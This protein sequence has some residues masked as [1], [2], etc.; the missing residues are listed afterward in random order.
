MVG[1]VLST[2]FTTCVAVAVCPEASV[3]VHITF[4]VPKENTLGALFV[5]L[6]TAQLSAATGVPNTTLNAAHALFA[7]TVTFAGA[8]IV[9]FVLSTTVTTCV[10]VAVKPDA[11]VTVQVTVVFPSGKATGALFVTLAT[12]QL[13]AVT[14]VPK[15]TPVAVQAVFVF[16]VIAAGA[17]IVG[18]TLSV[19]VIT[20]VAVAEFPAASVTVQV[21]VVLPIGKE[22][23][24]LFVTLATV[25]LSAVTGVPNETPV[26]V[27]P[28]FVL[29]ESAAGAVMVGST[30]SITVIV[31]VHCAVTFCASVIV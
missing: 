11:S 19:T 26:A 15:V 7:F 1:F 20:C 13:S 31:D 29:T 28:V 17:T 2:T 21:T 5:T 12:E 22:V 23:G 30:D 16:T 4:V 24:A 25:Q 10:A 14:G 9:G 8:V 6:A 18:G 3:T 27:Q